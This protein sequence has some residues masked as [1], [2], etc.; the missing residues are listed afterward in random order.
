[1][2]VKFD[3]PSNICT[4]LLRFEVVDIPRV[5]NTIFGRP[6]YIKFM[7]IPNYTYLKLKMPRP[8]RDYYGHC[9]F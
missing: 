2:L 4:E 5:Y 6:C 1:M 3:S 7:A 8:P 9:L